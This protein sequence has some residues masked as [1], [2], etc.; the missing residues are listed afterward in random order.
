MA[1]NGRSR[2]PGIPSYNDYVRV[3]SIKQTVGLM[4]E[5]CEPLIDL[6]SRAGDII[7]GHDKSGAR[8]FAAPNAKEA[9]D[10]VEKLKKA[11]DTIRD[12]RKAPKSTTPH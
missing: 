3:A 10:D 6:H 7:A 2:C 5:E 8:A 9:R 12:R 4:V 11:L 1:R